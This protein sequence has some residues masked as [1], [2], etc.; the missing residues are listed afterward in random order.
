MKFFNKKNVA[1]IKMK[2][3]RKLSYA[4]VKLDF[5]VGDNDNIFHIELV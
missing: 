2:N 5:A 4:Q 3:Q 1:A